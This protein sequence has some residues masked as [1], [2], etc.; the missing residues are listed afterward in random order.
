MLG[1]GGVAGGAFHAGV[2][3]ALADVTGWDPR[4]AAIVV[5]TSAGSVA[6][7]SLRAGLAAADMLARATDRPLSP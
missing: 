6:G 4:R 2:L 1:A 3:A 5:G 7:S